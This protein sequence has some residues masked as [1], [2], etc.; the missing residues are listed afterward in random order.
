[1]FFLPN[2]FCVPVRKLGTSVRKSTAKSD[3]QNLQNQYQCRSEQTSL[4]LICHS[5][6]IYENEVTD[7]V[8]LQTLCMH[9]IAVE[10]WASGGFSVK[11]IFMLNLLKEP[12]GPWMPCNH[13]YIH[14]KRQNTG[15]S[16]KGFCTK[17]F[18]SKIIH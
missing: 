18:N 14:L 17:D 2:I 15:T 16:A 6:E 7:F 1:M 13:F 12:H 10:A 8:A 5:E 11:L 9:A 4:P 3:L